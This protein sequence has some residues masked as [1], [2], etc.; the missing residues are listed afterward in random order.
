M[1]NEDW[2]ASEAHRKA[3][4]QQLL[5][6]IKV[7]FSLFAYALGHTHL[8]SPPPTPEALNVNLLKIAKKRAELREICLLINGQISHQPQRLTNQLHH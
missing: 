4:L 5:D 8:I 3:V 2:F 7:E 1:S 6:E